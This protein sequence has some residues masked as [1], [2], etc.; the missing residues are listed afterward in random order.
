M[1]IWKDNSRFP[2]AL[3][4]SLLAGAGL[5]MGTATAS[6]QVNHTVPADAIQPSV[7]D[8]SAIEA[9]LIKFPFPQPI[10][11]CVYVDDDAAPGGDGSSWANAFDTLTAALD[12]ASQPGSSINCIRV[13]QGTYA[14]GIEQPGS[15]R[16]ATFTLINNVDI[17]GGYAGVTE[18]NPNLR[19]ATAY[20]TILDGDTDQNDLPGN[21]LLQRGDNVYH[22]VT[23]DN[24][25]TSATALS[26]LTVRGGHA[27][28]QS[29]FNGDNGGGAILAGASPMFSVVTFKEN[30][31]ESDGGGAWANADAAPRFT[32]CVFSGNFANSNGGA[33][34]A[35]FAGTFLISGG[36]FTLND[37][38]DDGGAIYIRDSDRLFVRAD[39]TDNFA[40]RNGGAISASFVPLVT[41]SSLS[42]GYDF[43]RYGDNTALNNGG[44]FYFA[45]CDRAQFSSTIV[46]DN[47]AFF[48][49]GGAFISGDSDATFDDTSF[50]RNESGSEGGGLYAAFGTSVD[51]RAGVFQDNSSGSS[52]AGAYLTGQGDS[53]FLVVEFRGNRITA[54]GS[55][56][57]AGLFSSGRNLVLQRCGFT[58]NAF[59]HDSNGDGIGLYFTSGTLFANDCDFDNNTARFAGVDGGGA[60]V[61]GDATFVSSSFDNNTIGDFPPDLAVFGRGAG[62]YTNSTTRLERCFIRGNTNWSGDGGGLYLASNADAEIADCTVSSNWVGA[63]DVGDQGGGL[64]NAGATG[65][66]IFN[67]V[68]IDN[69]AIAG[70]GGGLFVDIS[71]NDRFELLN[72]EIRAN[73][74][75]LDG[76]GIA[77][78][79]GSTSTN[80]PDAM[81]NVLIVSNTAGSEGGGMWSRG[82]FEAGSMTIADNSAQTGGGWWVDNSADPSLNNSILYF[83]TPNQ[84]GTVS[85]SADPFLRNVTISSGGNA[86]DSNV[87][88]SDPQFADP[89]G[90]DNVFGNA[91]DNYRLALSSP[92]L[93][94]GND[95]LLPQDMRDL[96]MDL[97]I[98]EPL[99]VDLDRGP[100]IVGLATD[101]GAHEFADCNMNGVDDATDIEDGSETDCSGNGIPDSCEPDCNG[102][103][104][105]DSCDIFFGT[106]QDCNL[107]GIPDECEINA[108]TDC[109][110]DGI[111]DDCE[112]S[113]EVIFVIDTSSSNS[114]DIADIQEFLADGL[115]T[116]NTP[117]FV[118]DPLVLSIVPASFNGIEGSVTD[119]FTSAVPGDNGTCPNDIF[120]ASAPQEAWGSGTSVVA[121][122]NNW[123]AGIRIIIPISDENPCGGGTTCSFPTLQQADIDAIDNAVTQC[124]AQSVFAIP[125]TGA[126]SSQC[127]DAHAE[128]LATNTGGTTFSRNDYPSYQALAND[129]LPYVQALIDDAVPCFPLVAGEPIDPLLLPAVQALELWASGSPIMDLNHDGVVDMDDFA[130]YAGVNSS[131]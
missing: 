36:E 104:I 10:P 39:M 9:E 124:L 15:G 68:F 112:R 19:S 11:V 57:G 49:G 38:T 87:L 28:N 61:N 55:G 29:I 12:A 83:N 58:Q 1:G 74:A 2:Y 3:S 65:C 31:A 42:S 69:V 62:L 18:P 96:D 123:S 25:V 50:R 131:E 91:D 89:D 47:F 54:S 21:F 113:V 23:A 77:F 76:G 107:N 86:N 6:A 100:R 126:G 13:G 34:A 48:D 52:G 78:D 103:M 129:F 70:S 24:T 51:A 79:W 53:E 82:L 5:I 60:F 80:L 45:S 17:L 98:A 35:E 130:V 92:S 27:D 64:Y 127:V 122:N 46:E 120:S 90:A 88:T 85:A 14:P 72:T 99:P 116:L 106:S 30:F 117:G 43:E 110:G 111:L 16:S 105:A 67:T 119:L 114:G 26:L 56:N 108:T 118:L 33:L 7:I 115:L 66:F 20:P 41:I 71:T 97:N 40:G 44:A 102:N 32:N 75:G 73:D 63:F 59:D 109:D 8:V 93:D 121:F 94:A 125:I 22:V 101:H 128:T 84:L 95:A 81:T 37:A 4:T